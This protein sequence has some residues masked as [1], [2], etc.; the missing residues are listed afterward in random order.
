M[1]PFGY[2]WHMS[3]ASKC[4]IY[5][6]LHECCENKIAIMQMR[7]HVGRDDFAHRRRFEICRY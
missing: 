6:L 1:M 5:S 3:D 2:R 7:S 4:K